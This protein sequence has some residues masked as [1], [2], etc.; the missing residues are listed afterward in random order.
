MK[1]KVS[2]RMEVIKIRKL[3]NETEH[4]KNREKLMK[5]KAR[6]LRSIKLINLQPLT[7]RKREKMLITDIKNEKYDITLEFTDVKRII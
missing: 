7:G 1:L 2:R 3:I 5:P 4:R 6:S